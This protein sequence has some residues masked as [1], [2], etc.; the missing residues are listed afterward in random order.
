[1]YPSRRP[2][3][4]RANAQQEESRE[5][6]KR[7]RRFQVMRHLYVR[8][9]CHELTGHTLRVMGTTVRRIP[10]MGE[11]PDTFIVR[12][13]SCNVKHTGQCST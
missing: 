2:G 12:L 7:V 6:K 11:P 3:T 4:D 13:S 9:H 1:M 10:L 5:K 8:C